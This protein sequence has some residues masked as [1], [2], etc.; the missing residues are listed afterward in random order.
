MVRLSLFS[1]CGPYIIYSSA[2]ILSPSVLVKILLPFSNV[3][4]NSKFH[5]EIQI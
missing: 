2:K 1:G 4:K 5:Y 3:A